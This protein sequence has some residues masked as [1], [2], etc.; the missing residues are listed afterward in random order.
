M[1][2][3][4]TK[5]IL[6]ITSLVFSL[7]LC[8]GVIT[9]ALYY[10]SVQTRMAAPAEDVPERMISP[11]EA[12]APQEPYTIALLGTDARQPDVR[13]RTDTIIL[14]RVEPATRQ[15]WMV[16]IPRDTK[17]EIPGYGTRKINAAHAYGGPELA[18]EVIEELTGQHIDHYMTINF[19][20]FEEVIDALGGVTLDVPNT[21]E[22]EKAALADFTSDKSASRIEAG[23]QHLDGAHALTFVRYR[24]YIDGDFGRTYAQQMFFRAVLDQIDEVSLVRVPGLVDAI[25]SNVETNLTPIQLAQVAREMRGTKSENLYTITLEGEWH[26]PFVYLDEEFAQHVWQQFG[27]EP[28]DIPDHNLEAAD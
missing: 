24:G 21:I 22:G 25:A 19:F 27:V 9:G 7:L 14:A 11:E 5:K 18:I 23:L 3:P 20:G 16:S 2:N 17:V 10:I 12:L 13:D 15:V 28:F 1:L 6:V 8:A 4:R 26:S